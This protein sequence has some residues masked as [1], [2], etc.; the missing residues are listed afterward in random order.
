MRFILLALT[1]WNLNRF[2]QFFHY[3]SHSEHLLVHL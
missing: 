1:R 3:W 2:S